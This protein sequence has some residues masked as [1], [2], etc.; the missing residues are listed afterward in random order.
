MLSIRR[1]DSETLL[2]LG[3]THEQIADFIESIMS[4]YFENIKDNISRTKI[5]I[6]GERFS[7]KITSWCG[8]VS[9]PFS[10]GRERKVVPK[11][12]ILCR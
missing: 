1:R 12:E 9:C 3:I 4:V 8:F 11:E 2:S 5:E 7:M 10:K 6:F